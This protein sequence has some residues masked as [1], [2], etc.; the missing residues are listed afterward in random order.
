MTAP[1]PQHSAGGSSFARSAG[2]AAGRGILL[3]LFAVVIGAVLLGQGFDDDD[4]ATTGST[5]QTDDSSQTDD[6]GAEIGDITDQTA[7]DGSVTST[8]VAS[9]ARPPAE[10][11]VLVANGSRTD[12]V[13]S[14]NSDELNRL[15]YTV[16]QPTN[17]IDVATGQNTQVDQSTVYF[18]EG[19]Q[20]DATAVAEAL[21]I[22]ATQV[23]AMPVAPDAPPVADLGG[24]NVLVVIGLDG[25]G[26]GAS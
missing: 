3:I 17:A 13:A 19:Y 11:T 7:T 8:T 6:S 18:A 21:G 15:G 20:A 10:V 16:G 26:V 12:G 23:A 25:L 24:A 22:P 4:G 9:A 1:G 14:L 5:A 2:A